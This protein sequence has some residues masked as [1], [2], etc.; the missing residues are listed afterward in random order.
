M[1]GAVEELG[2]SVPL[3][4][5]EGAFGTCGKGWRFTSAP[6]EMAQGSQGREWLT[7]GLQQK[8]SE[9]AGESVRMDVTA[10]LAPAKT[11]ECWT[12]SVR[13]FCDPADYLPSSLL[14][15][16]DGIWHAH[17]TLGLINIQFLCYLLHSC[18]ITRTIF[19]LP[20]FCI[21]DQI[22]P[23]LLSP[24][25][26]HFRWAAMLFLGILLVSASS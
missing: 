24:S 26:G 3:A 5:Q 8:R 17:M 10:P 11:W 12:G 18:I 7:E 15:S 16:Q 23:R 19:K 25:Q 13:L 6:S 22:F 1:A 9:D 4:K 20:I 14:T 21:N 2:N